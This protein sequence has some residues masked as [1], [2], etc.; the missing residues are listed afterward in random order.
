MSGSFVPMTPE[1]QHY[2]TSR[3]TAHDPLLR[4][5]A[6]ETARLGGISVMQIATLQGTF[7]NLLGA[8]DLGA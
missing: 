3:S 8:R 6:E 4:E 5:L 1:L 7:M 2:I